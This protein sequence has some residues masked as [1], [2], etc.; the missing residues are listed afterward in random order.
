MEGWLVPLIAYT[1]VNGS[2]AALKDTFTSASSPLSQTVSF[3]DIKAR[4]GGIND[5]FNSTVSLYSERKELISVNGFG[6]IITLSVAHSSK[7]NK[8]SRTGS[9]F[10]VSLLK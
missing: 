9:I 4:K 8:G 1:K 5:I 7:R 3:P 2:T 6:L 10:T